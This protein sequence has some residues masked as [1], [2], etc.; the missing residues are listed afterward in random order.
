MKCVSTAADLPRSWKPSRNVFPWQNLTTAQHCMKTPTQL[1]PLAFYQTH[2]ILKMYAWGPHCTSRTSF[3]KSKTRQSSQH[4]QLGAW[5][6]LFDLG[7]VG[8][9]PFLHVSM[10]Q[11]GTEWRTD[12]NILPEHRSQCWPFGWPGAGVVQLMQNTA[13]P[14][15][16]LS[17]CCTCCTCCC[18][19]HE[20][21]NRQACALRHVRW[22]IFFVNK[23]RTNSQILTACCCGF[24]PDH[25]RHLGTSFSVCHFDGQVGGLD[26]KQWQNKI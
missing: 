10:L 19:G 7:L 9:A 8:E 24:I 18:T 20:A 2:F 4:G 26:S 17:T 21:E 12:W 5:F 25:G 11:H 14:R 22:H 16:P 1:H 15:P 13:T 6:W 3:Y 23:H